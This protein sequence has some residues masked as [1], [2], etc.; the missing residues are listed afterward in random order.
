MYQPLAEHLQN[1]QVYCV[2]M[3]GR[4]KRI[5]ESL[6]KD[7]NSLLA[8]IMPDVKQCVKKAERFFLWGDSL[9]AVL[10]YEAAKSLQGELVGAEMGLQGLIVSGNAGPTFA[11]LEQ[12]MGNNTTHSLGRECLSVADMSFDDW[13]KFFIAS[14]GKDRA[15]E[16]EALL[17]DEDLAEQALRP[18]IA[19]CEAYESY[20]HCD[21]TRIRSPIVTVRGEQDCITSHSVMK[22]WED[23][24][25]SRVEHIQIAGSGHMLARDAPKKLAEHIANISTDFE[26]IS[27]DKVDVIMA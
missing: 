16:L 13:K 19:D 9:G 23:V 18:L 1:M 11:A 12:G 20:N 10:A 24:A 2:E 15:K 4:G 22:S 3:P 25:A 27:P 5:D 6:E 7:F 8:N 21:G 26:A 17:A 14:S